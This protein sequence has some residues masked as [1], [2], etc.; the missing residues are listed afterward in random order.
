MTRR[1][2]RLEW[3]A[4]DRKTSLKKRRLGLLK[5][6]SELTTLCGVDACL[7]IYSPDQKEPVVWPDHDEVRRLLEEF[8]KIPQFERERKMVNQEMYLVEMATKVQEH[9]TKFH[10]KNKEVETGNFM[11]QIDR[12]KRID[13]LSIIEMHGVI[14]LLEEKMREIRNRYE[15]FQQYPSQPAGPSTHEYLPFPPQDP[16]DDGARVG[17]EGDGGRRTLSQSWLSD[18]WFIDMMMNIN[19]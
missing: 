19:R 8:H 3:I 12:G 9:M 1:K 16:T 13:E 7:I 6:V 11:H 5:K 15:I 2:G 10:R 17:L 4:N 18:Q 14:W